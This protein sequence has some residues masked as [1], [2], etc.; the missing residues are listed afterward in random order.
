ME[1]CKSGNLLLISHALNGFYDLYSE[2][3]YNQ[4]LIEKSVLPLMKAGLPQVH[5]LYKQA[6]KEKTLTKRELEF[7]EEA[8]LNL[9][10]FIDYKVNEL[11]L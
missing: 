10:A 7:V 2:A 6:V 3:F 8:L 1:A 4:V 11:K 9:Q 5:T